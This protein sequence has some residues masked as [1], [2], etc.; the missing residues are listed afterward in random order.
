M[1][2]LTAFYKRGYNYLYDGT[3]RKINP[4]TQL[5]LTSLQLL[6]KGAKT[7]RRTIYIYIRCN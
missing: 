4:F 6:G 1:D 7:K 5:T 3:E 2:L